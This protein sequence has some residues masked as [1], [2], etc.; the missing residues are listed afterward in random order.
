MATLN[1]IKSQWNIFIYTFSI[2]NKNVQ[3]LGINKTCFWQVHTT[4]RQEKI[5]HSWHIICYID[6]LQKNCIKAL[7]YYSKNC[8]IT[9]R[10]ADD[11]KHI[12]THVLVLLQNTESIFDW[13]MENFQKCGRDVLCLFWENFDDRDTL[14]VMKSPGQNR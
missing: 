11:R 14:Y 6:D 3:Y 12:L 1:G 9:Y 8:W 4:M 5:S 13:L 10:Q 2:C 7:V